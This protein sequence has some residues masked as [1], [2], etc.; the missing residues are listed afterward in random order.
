VRKDGPRLSKTSPKCQSAADNRGNVLF[1]AP[2]GQ[3][4]VYLLLDDFAWTNAGFDSGGNAE[5][6]ASILTDAVH[7]G[8]LGIDEYRH[9]HGRVESFLGVLWAVPGAPACV[10]MGALLALFYIYSRNV[11]FGPPDPY[12]LPE[13]RTARE[14]VEA[15]AHLNERA[16]A[17]PLAVAAVLERLRHLAGQ[18]GHFPPEGMAAMESAEE[19]LRKGDRPARPTEACRLVADLVRLRKQ[20]QG[21]GQTRVYI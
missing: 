7:G 9:G 16:R 6:L 11:R 1:R 14:Y 18:R 21:L 12:H 4:A 15:V 2:W 17:A 20:W 19:Y 5:A 3:G 13:R 10:A 8:V